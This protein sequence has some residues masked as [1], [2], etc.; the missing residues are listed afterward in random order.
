MCFSKEVS[1][2]TYI[3][4][5]TGSKLLF[6][7]GYQIEAIFYGWVIHMQLIEF[8]LWKYQPCSKYVSENNNVTKMGLAVN[9]LEPIILWF[10][11]LK[12][13]KLPSQMNWFMIIFSVLTILYLKQG[14]HKT[15]CTT[16]TEESKPHLMWKWNTYN[17]YYPYYFLF[18]ISLLVLFK[19]G[20]PGKRG[21]INAFVL[22]LSFMLSFIIYRGKNVVGSMWCFIVILAPYVVLYLDARP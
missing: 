18:L 12:F 22:L 13:S 21:K 19:Y 1:L 11:V 8:F 16:V 5:L 6:D 10:A 9:H 3:I 2:L 15:D 17:Y 20:I 14:Y 4:G 7:K